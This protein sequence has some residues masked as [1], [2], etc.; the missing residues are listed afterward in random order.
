[1]LIY[2]ASLLKITGA[3]A[4]KLFKQ[5]SL[6]LSAPSVIDIVGCFFQAGR[7]LANCAQNTQP[8][9]WLNTLLGTAINAPS[10]VIF[11]GSQ[12]L[13][14]WILLIILLFLVI[15]DGSSGDVVRGGGRERCH[16]LKAQH[17]WSWNPFIPQAG[18]NYPSLP[19]VRSAFIPAR[20]RLH[21]TNRKR[22]IVCFVLYLR[23]HGSLNKEK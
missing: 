15:G 1:M 16:G 4:V 14:H 13:I 19:Q 10:L 18:P 20:A 17:T 6:I 2:G 9:I 12:Q 3:S 7:S 22:L 8:L 11:N 5:S 23:G 21:P